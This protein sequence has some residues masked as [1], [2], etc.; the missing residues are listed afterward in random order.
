VYPSKLKAGGLGRKI[1][2]T[3]QHLVQ[4][5]YSPLI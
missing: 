3:V 1:I 5:V 4:S 2:E